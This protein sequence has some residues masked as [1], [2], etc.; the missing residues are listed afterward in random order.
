MKTYYTNSYDTR[1]KER[2]R[3]TQRKMHEINTELAE[4][5]KSW[6]YKIWKFIKGG[7]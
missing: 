5:K 4:I 1:L 2:M 6:V 7:T 3:D